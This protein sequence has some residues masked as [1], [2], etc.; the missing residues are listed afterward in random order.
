MVVTC[1]A[2]KARLNVPEDKIPVGQKVNLKCP[3]CQHRIVLIG[4][5]SDLPSPEGHIPEPPPLGER[6]VSEGDSLESSGDDW[7]DDSEMDFFTGT[8]RLAL[9]LNRDQRSSRF[10]TRVLEELSY[11]PVLA[12]NA[13]KA[14]GKMRFHSFALVFLT[15]G[16]DGPL[17]TSPILQHINR[18]SMFSRRGMFLVLMSDRCKTMDRLTA[19]SL[20]ANLVV[21]PADMNKMPHILETGISEHER[22]YKVFIDTLKEIGKA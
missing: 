8:S 13:E 1:E 15:E 21:N 17:E 4:S 2:C 18:L 5:D 16:F 12:E 9:V 20:S 7:Q 19:F 6:G 3:R 10:L 14:I 22:F 11:R